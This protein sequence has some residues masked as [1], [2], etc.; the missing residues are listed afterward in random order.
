MNK[1]L[2]YKVCGGIKT[3]ITGKLLYVVLIELSGENGEVVIPQRRISEALHISK[4]TVSRNL[5]RLE[6][7]GAISIIPTYHSDGGSAA[8]KYLVK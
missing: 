6:R 5:R 8:N 4:G 7:V 3:T 2:K 1:L